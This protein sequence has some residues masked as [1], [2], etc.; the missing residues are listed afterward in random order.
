MLP[1]TMYLLLLHRGLTLPID[2]TYR[3]FFRLT[4]S[5]WYKTVILRRGKDRDD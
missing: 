3:N 4:Y 2:T 5:N 1:T